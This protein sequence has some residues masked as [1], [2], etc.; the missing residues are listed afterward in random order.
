VHEGIATFF[1][2]N[3]VAGNCGAVHL[4][5]DFVVA[6]PTSTYANGA[7]CG[8]KVVVM[9]ADTGHTEF[10]TVADSCPTCGGPDD[11]DMSVALFS[12]FATLDKGIFNLKWAF[13]Q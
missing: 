8:K 2:Q 6:L 1:Y 10:A 9:D 13:A 12:Q 7:F 4:D 11:L 5:A 3:G